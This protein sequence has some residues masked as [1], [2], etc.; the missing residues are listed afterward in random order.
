MN[1]AHI[2]LVVNHVPLFAA[3]FGGALLAYG[4]WKNERS[5][6]SAGLV[7]GVI[8]GLSGVAAVQSGERA[9]DIVEEY[10]GT[11]E[12]ALEEHEEA[13]ETTQWAAILLGLVSLTALFLPKDRTTLRGRTEWLAVAL[14]LITLAMVARTAN[15][16][17]PI[18][19]PEIGSPGSVVDTD[20][21][22]DEDDHR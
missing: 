19:H 17:G 2:H 3:L 7:L 5:L 9:E 11:N 8:A 4:L 10:A 21:A 12:R 15:L 14:F 18:R 16:G 20:G 6:K 22:E 1:P 13:A